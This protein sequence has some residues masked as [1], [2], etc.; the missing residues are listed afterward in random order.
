MLHNFYIRTASPEDADDIL[1]WRNDPEVCAMSLNPEP[2][3][4]S[5]HYEWYT[6]VLNN[7]DRL[8]LIGIFDSRK[9]GF[10]RF[11]RRDS[12]LW[13]VSIVIAASMRGK[14][15][16][17]YFLCNGLDRLFAE[18]GP[19]DVRATVHKSNHASLALFQSLRFQETGEEDGTFVMFLL[20]SIID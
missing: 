1:N 20:P 6:G 14:G 15:V 13:E 3:T 5:A 11:D 10:V 17:R 19:A 18:Q 4:E 12:L 8:L 9:V 16:G 7:P 2:V